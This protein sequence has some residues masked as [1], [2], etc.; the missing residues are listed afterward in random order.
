MLNFIQIHN[1]AI[2]D[3][4][5]LELDTGLTVLTG[6]T[7]AG[8][9]ILVDALGLVLGDRADASALRHGAERGEITA[10]FHLEAKSAAGA[11][12][13]EQDLDDDNECMV[14]RTLSRNGRSR[15]FINAR[16]VPLGMLRKLGEFL[17]D[18][19]GQHEHQSLVRPAVQR[20]ILDHLG[21]NQARA[22]KVRQAF[23]AWS[24]VNRDID[25]LRAKDA[26]RASRLEL[27]EYQVRELAS[28]APA[29]D[30]LAQLD[31]EHRKLAGAGQLAEGVQ[32][33]LAALGGL[34]G[35]GGADESIGLSERA[36][37]ELV[38]ID[39][40]LSEPARLVADAGIHVQEAIDSLRRYL[41][42]LEMDPA[43]LD[44]VETRISALYEVARKHKVE[45]AA[46]PTLARQLGAELE[47]LKGT[48]A[49]LEAMQA[50]LDRCEQAYRAAAGKLSKARATAA[51][52][53]SE[54]V[55]A[56]MQ[57]L[58]MPGG[59]FEAS[60]TATPEL[61][62]SEHGGDIIEFRVT[63]NPGH[64]PG[65]LGKVA[66]GGELSRISL[67][68]QVIAAG[69]TTTG[70]LVFD[71]VDAGVGGG[72]AE[73]VGRRLRELGSDHQVLCVTHLPQVASQA[74][75]HVRV[76]KLTDGKTTRTTLRPLT[77]DES[78]EELA[79]MLGGVEITRRTREHAREMI[80]K[81]REG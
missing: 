8:K 22:E 39:A 31:D 15:A 24:S 32:Q 50:D 59:R 56:M 79:R 1:F 26:D 41:D 43:R 58:G 66:S 52:R 45:A 77:R 73:I 76:S 7:G 4:V 34:D 30:E 61:G 51:Q 37:Q 29:E 75:H 6:E 13:A 46:L 36:L 63:A 80:D 18:I 47:T 20:Q 12:L 67:A 28:L 69:A 54:E 11:W 9:S 38:E 53:M 25:A 5:E 55:S 10:S 60:V 74:H 64:P 33:A 81:A 78:V 27:L 71:E 17:A 19:H 40:A 68:I 23:F 48:D 16:A 70:C 57:A 62:P 65:S 2:I 35:E 44:W 42:A 72:V 3:E 14:R 21:G 49:R